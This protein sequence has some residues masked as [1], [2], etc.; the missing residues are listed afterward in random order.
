[1][2]LVS[3]DREF[4]NNVVTSTIVFE[5]GGAKEYDGGY[6]D[7]LRQRPG[8]PSG[9]AEDKSSPKSVA[10]GIT[11]TKDSPDAP[12]AR[13]RTY[14]ERQEYEGLPGKIESIEAEIAAL[15]ADMGQPDFYQRSGDA[16]AVETARLKQLEGDLTKAY[17]RWEILEKLAE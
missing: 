13:K 15:H 4:L 17:K 14:K 12:R 10:K 6:D 11:A 9:K 3:H 16:I 8:G 7:W 2:L 5:P 1:V